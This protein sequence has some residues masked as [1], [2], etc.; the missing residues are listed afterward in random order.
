MGIATKRQALSLHHG[1][2]ETCTDSEI[3]RIW[4]TLDEARKEQ[5]LQELN[6]QKGKTQNAVRNPSKPDLRKSL[7]H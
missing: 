7:K 4:N 5:Y 3:V 1:G 6:Q 2:L